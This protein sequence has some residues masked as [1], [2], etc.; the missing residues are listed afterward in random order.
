MGGARAAYRSSGMICSELVSGPRFN[1][2]H[3]TLR[4]IT[5]LTAEV[6][7]GPENIPPKKTNPDETRTDQ[8]DQTTG[9]PVASDFPPP[10]LAEVE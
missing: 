7:P 5:A 9:P 6:A 1:Q 2:K 8:N 3:K 10:Y 4:S